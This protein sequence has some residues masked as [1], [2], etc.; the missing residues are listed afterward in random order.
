MQVGGSGWG[1]EGGW[2]VV[3]GDWVPLTTSIQ[4]SETHTHTSDSGGTHTPVPPLTHGGGPCIHLQVCIGVW[5][6]VCVCVCVERR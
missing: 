1:G 3:R 5:G 4:L 2:E 6:C